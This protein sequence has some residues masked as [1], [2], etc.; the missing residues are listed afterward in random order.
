MKFEEKE[1][2]IRGFVFFISGVIGLPYTLFIQ[3]DVSIYFVINLITSLL[4]FLGGSILMIL[5]LAGKFQKVTKYPH[6]SPLFIKIMIGVFSAPGVILLILFFRNPMHA[7]GLIYSTLSWGFVGYII[8]YY[9]NQN[10]TNKLEKS[11]LLTSV[12]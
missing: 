8:W 1:R 4:F 9:F 5:T 2:F 3:Y 11:D 6:Y 10:Q 7:G 12:L